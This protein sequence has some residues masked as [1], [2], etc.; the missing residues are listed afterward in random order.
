MKQALL[1]SVVISRKGEEDDPVSI[2]TK[3]LEDLQKTLDD[4]LKK[5]E[6]GV[7]IKALTDRI[8]E[9][10]TKANRPGGKKSGDEQ[11]EIERKALAS[12]LRNAVSSVIEDAGGAFES[13]SAAS[14]DNDPSGGYFVLPTIDYSI[15]T[16]MTDLSPLRGLAEVVSISSDRYERF[17]SMGR[18]GAQWVA[19]RDDRPQ[20]TARP[21]LIKH[22]YPVMELYAAP[23]ATRHLLDDAATDIASWLVNNATHDF[24]ET[25]GEAFLR[26]DGVEGKPRG[27]LDYG[28]TPEK[29][30]VRPWGKHQYVA[31]GHASAPTDDMLTT[32]VIKLISALRRPYKGNAVFLMNSNTAVRLRTIK[33]ANGRFLWAPTG[34]LIEGVEHPLMG[35]RVEIDEG[36]PDIGAGEHPIAFGDFRQ[37]YVV[38]DRQGVRVNRDELTQKGRIV[39]DVYR[40][41]G[42]G[43]GDFNAVKF[44]K[45][46]AA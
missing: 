20:D 42:G 5:V 6:G 14:S 31:A 39:F 34:N 2:V 4:R 8:A 13:K 41:V 32:A 7:E 3:S 16:L 11:L 22:S 29:D 44:L 46:A 27:L 38:V 15:R 17:Y 24:A 37:A 12:Y 28:T 36:M 45:I 26:G 40:R 25:E 21:E 23:V 33:D 9:L 10:E 18:R 1:G 35:Y 19:E 30:F 43:A